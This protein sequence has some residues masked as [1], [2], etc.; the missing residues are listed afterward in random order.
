MYLGSRVANSFRLAQD[1]PSISTGSPKSQETPQPQANRDRWPP[2]LQERNLMLNHSERI[3]K[4]IFLTVIT[5]DF[6]VLEKSE[7]TCSQRTLHRIACPSQDPT[8][9]IIKTVQ[10]GADI[11]NACSKWVDMKECGDNSYKHNSMEVTLEHCIHWDAI[12]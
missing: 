7:A 2:Y 11:F 6:F 10:V 5:S 9:L 3:G 1:F 12:W 4:E 8:Y